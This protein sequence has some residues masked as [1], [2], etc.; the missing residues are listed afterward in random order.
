[1]FEKKLDDEVNGNRTAK[2]MLAAA[3]AMR[4]LKQHLDKHNVKCNDNATIDC[5]K[6]VADSF[7]VRIGKYENNVF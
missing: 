3:A 5:G 7:I 1:M 6:S 2:N 4:I